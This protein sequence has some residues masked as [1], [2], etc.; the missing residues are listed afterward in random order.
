VTLGLKFYSEVSGSVTGVR[1]S[2]GVGNTGS[3]VG[4]LWSST[5]AKLAEISFASETASGWQQANFSS[6]VPIAANT[7]YTVSYFAPRAHYANDQNYPWSSLSATPLHVASAAPGVYAYGASRSFPA[8][9]WNAS[10][11]W[12]DVVFAPGSATPPA[13]SYTISGVVSGSAATVTL[14]GAAAKS[15][16]TDA[17]GAYSFSGVPNGSYTVAVSQ[18]GYTFTP[19]TASVTVNGNSVSGVNFSSTAVFHSVTLSWTASASDNIV[20]YNVYRGSTSGGPY[21]QIA[22]VGGTSY[23]DSGVSAGQTYFYTATAVDSTSHESPYAA[24]AVAV[25]PIP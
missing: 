17:T 5:G 12:V 2:K 4:N 24:Q 1:F 19:A 11:Y 3:H 20:G 21:T 13:V 7:T 25:I 10:N 6:P 15:T 22:F 14:S 8:A 23:Q 16:I 9:S 18:P